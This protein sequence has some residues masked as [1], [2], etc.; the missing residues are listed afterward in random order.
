MQVSC[1]STV[2]FP[3]PVGVCVCVCLSQTGGVAVSSPTHLLLNRTQQP[4]AYKSRSCTPLFARLF[5]VLNV[6]LQPPTY[7][8]VLPTNSVF[9]HTSCSSSLVLLACLLCSMPCLSQVCWMFLFTTSSA[10]TC[11]AQLLITACS[12]SRSHLATATVHCL[13]PISYI[14]LFLGLHLC[15]VILTFRPN[16][17]FL[18]TVVDILMRYVET[19]HFFPHNIFSFMLWHHCAYTLKTTWSGLGK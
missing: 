8:L 14:S 6:T 9:T 2:S 1:L 17:I 16:S 12:T 18:Q 15:S 4:A 13:C 10:T 5:C 11:L 3:V 7:S 19:A